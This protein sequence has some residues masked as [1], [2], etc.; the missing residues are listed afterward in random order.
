MLLFFWN[1]DGQKES[2]LTSSHQERSHISGVQV[3]H[4]FLK[5]FFCADSLT[6]DLLNQIL[7]PQVSFRCRAAGDYPRDHHSLFTL[8][9]EL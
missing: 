5:L 8:I 6:V 3:P 4:R 7:P 9:S 2:V 1:L